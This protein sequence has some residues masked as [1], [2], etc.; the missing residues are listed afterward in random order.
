MVRLLPDQHVQGRQR[1]AVRQRQR[2]SA[3]GAP[4]RGCAEGAVLRPALQVV[5]GSEVSGGPDRRRR[6]RHGRGDGARE[7]RG[8]RR[9]GR[10]R[11]GDPEAGHRLPPRPPVPGSAGHA[12]RERRPGVPARHGQE[13]RPRD[14]RAARL[15]DAR[16]HD[17]EHPAR[18]VPVHPAGVR[19]RA[20]PPEPEWRV[21]ALQLLPRGV[22]D[23]EDRV[24]ARHDVR[25]PADRP[26]VRRE[27]GHLRRRPVDRRAARRPAA[28]RHGRRRARRRRSGAR[29]P[30]RTTGPSSTCA[31]RSSRRTTSRG[32]DSC[33]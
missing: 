33:C 18:V 28:G 16:Q 19:V 21:R 22:A 3:P 25:Q 7:R 27:E 14:L 1:R 24:D 11:Q 20:R 9:C 13:V 30:P 23:L 10:D 12:L 29:R 17:R 8:P 4:P 6:L 26:A 31:R 32:L 15:A 2:H 5:P